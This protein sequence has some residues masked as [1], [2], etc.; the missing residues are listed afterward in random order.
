MHESQINDIFISSAVMRTINHLPDA[1]RGAVVGALASR[2]LTG[3]EDGDVALSGIE[4]AACAMIWDTI[5]RESYR[6][7]RG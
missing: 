4:A 2:L 6:Y 3:N 7:A 5:Q 1:I